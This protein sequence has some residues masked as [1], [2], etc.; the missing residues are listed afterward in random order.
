MSTP[1]K[2][3]NV[4]RAFSARPRGSYKLIKGQNKSKKN[5]QKINVYTKYQNSN[6][7]L[8]E[9]IDKMKCF[10]ALLHRTHDLKSLLLLDTYGINYSNELKKI[11]NSKKKNIFPVPHNYN[12]SMKNQ[13][14]NKK[15]KKKEKKPEKFF[16]SD[17]S[18]KN[19]KLEDNNNKDIENGFD[20]TKEI[21]SKKDKYLGEQYLHIIKNSRKLLNLKTQILLLDKNKLYSEKKNKK[22]EFIRANI[23]KN[24]YNKIKS[25]YKRPSTAIYRK[26]TNIE[27]KF[28]NSSN[29]SNYKNKRKDENKFNYYRKNHNSN[30]ENTTESRDSMTSNI[31]LYKI[32]KLN[33]R[34]V[35][36]R[37]KFK[38]TMFTK[39]YQDTCGFDSR[40]ESSIFNKTSVRY[41]PNKKN[42]FSKNFNYSISMQ[43]KKN[44][45]IDSLNKL[46]NKSNIINQ[47]FSIFS[48]ESHDLGNKLFN[49]TYKTK[50]KEELNLKEINEYFNFDKGFEKDIES[51]LKNNAKKVKKIMDSKCG[52]ILD[53]IVK[54]ICLE[55][56]KLNKNHFLSFRNDKIFDKKNSMLKKYNKEFKNEKKNNIFDMFKKKDEDFFDIIK[57]GKNYISD[58]EQQYIKTKILNKFKNLK[59]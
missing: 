9:L 48:N 6:V 2:N 49:R 35:P 5:K 10:K 50:E 22:L 40:N 20:L 59:S 27:S 13:E 17:N 32:S 46:E 25:K 21:D 8:N 47:D 38:Q 39:E 11:I 19:I 44:Y 29:N 36:I 18:K 4:R 7:Y 1:E 28:Y 43:S 26:K 16:S 56:I 55:E 12:F 52:K 54:K 58:I 14:Q 23:N 41:Y 33:Q 45:F 57:S 51:L 31:L 3:K 30:I 34:Y 24:T 37:D 53:K 15:I 42:N